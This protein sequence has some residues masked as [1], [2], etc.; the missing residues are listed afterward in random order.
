MSEMSWFQ[1]TNG[2]K[3][4]LLFLAGF[5][6][7][8]I[9]LGIV[10]AIEPYWGDFNTELTGFIGV[11]LNYVSILIPLL[12][13][14]VI[15]TGILALVNIRRL[16]R[17]NIAKPALLHI[18][19]SLIFLILFDLLLVVLLLLF[20]EEAAI[21]GAVLENASIFIFLSVS[22]ALFVVLYPFLIVIHDWIKAP[23]GTGL[24][25]R[26]KAIILLICIVV[27]YGMAFLLPFLFAP[28]NV[29][30]GPLPPKPLI[31]AHRGAAHLAPENTLV[32]AEL[33]YNLSC[34]G[35]EI[36]IQISSDGIPFLMHDDT[37]ERS[38][39][40]EEIFPALI[41]EP[42]SNFTLAELKQL[43]AGTWFVEND[44]YGAIA[45]G[46]VSPAQILAFQN[47]SIPTLVE[48]INFTKSHNLILDADFKEPP[49]DHPHYADY[50]NTCLSLL[51]SSGLN[52]KIWIAVGN[53]NWLDITKAYTNLTTAWMITTSSPP[54]VAEF[55]T[56]G[57]E[58]VNT[59]YAQ[60]DALFNAYFAAG[61]PIN[62]Y[63]VDLVE[64]YS[65][66][67]CLGITFVTTN[68]PHK[69][70]NLTQP[71][72]YMHLDTYM[73]LWITIYLLGLS[74]V[75]IL[76]HEHTLPPKGID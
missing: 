43:N 62:A 26:V 48:A 69:F 17:T 29:L 42:A 23:E 36:D 72:W 32:S 4:V 71:N 5:I 37:L 14:P 3:W 19:V 76:K 64:L 24:N 1:K 67:W 8:F 39:N 74:F 51:N 7:I 65:Q 11:Q 50:F 21:V 60:S 45:K 10:L 41:K 9:I 27:G 33:A 12:V 53:R 54:S 13:I 61:I 31:I 22:I 55:Q 59:H 44:P 2:K 16:I 56:N 38:T 66:L 49:A 57:Y 18:I 35:W 20:G 15:Y 28:A 58:M 73:I 70:V 6:N 68:E 47:A 75:F 30:R 40:V 63:T 52:K 25:P 34:D 46:L